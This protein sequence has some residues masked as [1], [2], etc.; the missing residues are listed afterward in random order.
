MSDTAS[1]TALA[2]VYVILVV[3]ILITAFS[4]SGS[5]YDMQRRIGQLEVQVQRLEQR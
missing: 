3:M 5:D 1:G 2:F 4:L